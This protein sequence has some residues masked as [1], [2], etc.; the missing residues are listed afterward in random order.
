MWRKRFDT[1]AL[2][3]NVWSRESQTLLFVCM[4]AMTKEHS[5]IY[6]YLLEDVAEEPSCLVGTKFTAAAN[7]L[8][9]FTFFFYWTQ[10]RGA[11]WCT[12]SWNV[13]SFQHLL[14]AIVPCVCVYPLKT[15]W[16]WTFWKEMEGTTPEQCYKLYL[17]VCWM[18]K[19]SQAPPLLI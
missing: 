17:D 1:H 13:S 8:H 9:H 12:T 18:Q 3:V 16:G 2:E 4:A 15:L 6:L 11:D 14:M 7:V 10:I 5:H 19:S